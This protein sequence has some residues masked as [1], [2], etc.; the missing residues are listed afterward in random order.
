[1]EARTHFGKQKKTQED[2]L[3]DYSV[4]IGMLYNG[5]PIRTVTKVTGTSHAVVA[6]LKQM[7]C[8]N[9]GNIVRN[10]N[11]SGKRGKKV[12]QYTKDGKLVK[13]WRSHYEAA[14]E[15]NFPN[16]S[17]FI[18]F[19]IDGKM[20]THKGYMW[21]HVEDINNVPKTIQPADI[22]YGIRQSRKV[23]QYTLSGKLM[24]TYN[25][26]NQACKENP[27]FNSGGI[28]SNLKGISKTH[29]GY[30]WK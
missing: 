11:Q 4:E 19:C 10:P 14:K 23:S 5:T 2:Y 28:S 20:K 7:F 27:Q 22:Q 18:Q 16:Q 17:G 13:V 15:L 29:K 6:K 3:N 24:K 9:V 12:A 1:M 25:S 26:I 30:I 8:K 21:R